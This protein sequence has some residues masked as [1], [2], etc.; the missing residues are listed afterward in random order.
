MS[1]RVRAA[2]VVLVAMLAPASAI[3][4]AAAP[5]ASAEATLRHYFAALDA[6]D[7][8][9]VE[10]LR[11]GYGENCEATETVTLETLEH[12][13]QAGAWQVFKVR[14]N[15]NRGEP[16]PFSLYFP[17]EE[18]GGHWVIV[19]EAVS[20][21]FDLD[22]H[23][24][25]AEVVRPP[26]ERTEAPPAKPVTASDA[27][28]FR[29]ADDTR[30][31]VTV[32]PLLDQDQQTVIE[33][34]ESTAQ[35]RE[36][37]QRFYDALQEHRCVDALELRPDYPMRKCEAITAVEGPDIVSLNAFEGFEL[38]H[39]SVKLTLGPEVD[40]F[41]GFAAVKQRFPDWV[42]VTDLVMRDVPLDEYKAELIR[43]VALTSA[44]PS[45][46]TA[47]EPE[48]VLEWGKVGL[49]P[50]SNGSAAVLDQCWSTVKLAHQRGEEL[51]YTS[52][53][54]TNLG[55]PDRARRIASRNRD[56]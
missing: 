48:R 37:I 24:I 15:V 32:P 8:D 14:G 11:P 41:N 44:V 56:R 50:V 47:Y 27:S 49:P 34:P 45:T 38:F 10:Q 5:L 30:V 18:R 20:R 54:D 16:R 6:K 25:A 51:S 7:C 46:G 17:L 28:L 53:P 2:S 52:G 43:H 13:G 3:T 23:R 42:I 40:D 31:R 33:L 55:P 29:Q 12:E 21:E 1:W 19:D 26:V 9:T 35:A 22:A 4:Q 36:I 39:I